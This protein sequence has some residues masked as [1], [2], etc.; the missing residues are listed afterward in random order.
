LENNNNMVN[1][2]FIVSPDETIYYR[3]QPSTKWYHVAWKLVSGLLAI[4]IF[5]YISVNAFTNIA[6]SILFNRIPPAS[7]S[8]FSQ[9]LCTWIVPL[10][11]VAWF[12]E[13]FIQTFTSEFILTDRRVWVKGSPYAWNPGRNILLGEIES[14]VFRRGAIFIRCRSDRRPQI[15]M[16]PDG[17][18][19]VNTYQELIQRTG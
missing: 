14:M 8:F 17:R 2:A 16:F 18:V 1:S 6:G 19:I 10:L 4:I 7:A 15:H 13:D 5:V 3:S 11:A 9:L 12:V